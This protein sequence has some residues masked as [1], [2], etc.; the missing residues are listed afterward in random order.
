MLMGVGIDS[1]AIEEYF[2]VNCVVSSP[3]QMMKSFVKSYLELS[4]LF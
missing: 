3:F 4:S 2:T 1:H